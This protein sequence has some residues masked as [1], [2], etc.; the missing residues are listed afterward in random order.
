MKLFILIAGF[1]WS[2]C[3]T[4]VSATEPISPSALS[5]FQTSFSAA[6]DVAWLDMGTMY[7]VSF[8]MDKAYVTA[9]YNPD[10]HLVAVTRNLSPS[11]LPVKL[12]KALQK[13]LAHSWI[14]DLVTVTNE[15]GTSY[16]VSLENADSRVVLK[17]SGNRKWTFYKSE[18][19]S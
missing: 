19:K 11:T 1:L 2:S 13:E 18:E 7:K 16:F 9:F 3:F 17:S 8:V 12:Q 6:T 4:T 15:E 10:G 5:S 14:T